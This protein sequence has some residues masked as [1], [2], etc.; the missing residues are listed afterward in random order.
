[1][2]TTQWVLLLLLALMAVASLAV[3]TSSTEAEQIMDE[4]ESEE[5]EKEAAHAHTQHGL[6]LHAFVAH[7]ADSKSGGKLALKEV[8]VDGKGGVTISQPKSASQA[9][10]A[11]PTMPVPQS[12]I[13]YVK[14]ALIM[15]QKR[16]D[17]AKSKM[18]IKVKVVQ[19]AENRVLA[20]TNEPNQFTM[21][22]TA[23]DGL[24]R[25]KQTL[26]RAKEAYE[27]AMVGYAAAQKRF[28]ELKAQ[29]VKVQNEPVYLG[30][31][32]D[33]PPPK[34]R[35]LPT[36][37][38][39][40]GGLFVSKLFALKLCAA[41][42][43]DEGDNIVGLQNGYECWSGNSKEDNHAKYGVQDDPTQCGAFGGGWTNQVYKLY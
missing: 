24:V 20:A 1:M 18:D 16:L 29:A 31:Y 13:S 38:G 3:E 2:N 26:V 6:Q 37:N 4:V 32:K 8:S 33:A 17:F 5:E 15:G 12:N 40:V 14:R 25:A 30:C 43:L 10:T 41:K 19:D 11:M 39:R 23:K 27:E 7:T 36:G 42:A 35:A 9:P 34:S 28:E 22:P 21:S